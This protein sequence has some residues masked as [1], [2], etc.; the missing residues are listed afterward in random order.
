MK[1]VDSNIGQAS[2]LKMCFAS[3][4]KG[5]TAIAIQSFTTAQQLGVLS[6]LQG[7]LKEYSPKTG[8][9]AMKGLVGMP[10]KAYRWVR[11]M[12]E[13]ADT[14]NEEGGFDKDMLSGA[15]EVY[16][17]VS[18]DTDLGAEKTEARDRGRDPEDVAKLVA[19]G[20]ERKK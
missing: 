6:E 11:E 20:I 1:H 14:F 18:E 9:L 2:G 4:T 3:T 16:R 15:S 7:H 13:I 17:I 19:S 5:F 12:Q 8:D 10:P